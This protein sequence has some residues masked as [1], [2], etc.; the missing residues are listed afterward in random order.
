MKVATILDQIDMCSLNLPQFQ[1][2]Y[3]WSRPQ[4]RNLMR[5]LYRDYPVGGLLIWDTHASANLVRSSEKR[6]RF[7][8]SYYSMVSSA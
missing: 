1:R 5:S 7:L 4:V 3:V 2:G 8:R 6:W